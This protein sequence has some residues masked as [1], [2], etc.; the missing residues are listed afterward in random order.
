MKSAIDNVSKYGTSFGTG[1]NVFGTSVDINKSP[2]V[3]KS[4][5]FLNDAE[6]LLGDESVLAKMAAGGQTVQD[7]FIAKIK[8]SYGIITNSMARAKLKDEQVLIPKFGPNVESII[9]G[10]ATIIDFI[11]ENTGADGVFIE[12]TENGREPQPFMLT[13]PK[14]K[15]SY[16]T[17]ANNVLPEGT[18]HAQFAEYYWEN[19]LSLV[20]GMTPDKKGKYLDGAVSLGI[21]IPNIAAFDPGVGFITD[22]M[23]IE[24]YPIIQSIAGDKM[25]DQVLMLAPH[26]TPPNVQR[27]EIPGFR[28]IVTGETA[29]EYVLKATGNIYKSFGEIEE[30]ASAINTTYDQLLKIEEIRRNPKMKSVTAYNAIVKY[31]FGVVDIGKAAITDLFSSM[32]EGVETDRVLN[33]GER[34]IDDKYLE[35]LQKRI[36]DSPY[37][38]YEALNIALAF[39]LARAADP[40]GRLS[41]QDIEQQLRRL[42]DPMDSQA[43]ALAK[44]G[45]LIDEIGAERDK[46]Q[47]LATYGRGTDVINQDKA[48]VIDA[49]LVLS[50][51]RSKSKN[52]AA[53]QETYTP[54]NAPMKNR[55]TKNGDDVYVA[56]EDGVP[57]KPIVLVDGDG[58]PLDPEQVVT[59]ETPAPAPATKTAPA[60]SESK[61]PVGTE[62]APVA[63]PEDTSD[64]TNKSP[65]V[66]TEMAPV[67]A[68][69]PP[70]DTKKAPPSDDTAVP[71]IGTPYISGNNV[72]GF[73]FEGFEGLY[74]WNSTNKTFEKKKN[75]LGY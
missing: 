69:K 50:D 6:R 5:V 47:V 71:T 35:K 10:K 1:A 29:Q 12:E 13:D 44:I 55:K 68:D 45:I 20:V 70:A 38:E 9:N 52:N 53:N 36:D 24:F 57:R 48:R 23:A 4:Y 37:A 17:I 61:P 30:R 26:M 54:S 2:D 67:A 32:K 14:A 43:A 49:A 18:N 46:L 62:T 11:S 27:T 60:T 39:K 19:Y 40:S 59:V 42:G 72:D 3:A 28:T 51:M 25:I 16:S 56:I 31:A 73:K 34:Y 7:E 21:K 63:T 41:N 22:E 65:A 66:D 64:A 33:E 15:A 58:N 8:A 75:K 74:I